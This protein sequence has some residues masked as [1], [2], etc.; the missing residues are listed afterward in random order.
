[1]VIK[2]KTENF[3]CNFYGKVKDILIPK[4]VEIISSGYKE[5]MSK[6]ELAFIYLQ[7]GLLSKK[8]WL[9]QTRGIYC[10]LHS[11]CCQIDS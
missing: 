7:A 2:N 9:L 5:Y 6:L 8:E 11:E 4:S 10:C 1:M 3:V